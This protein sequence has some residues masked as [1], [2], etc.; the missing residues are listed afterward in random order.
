MYMLY[1]EVLILF[2]QINY[3]CSTAGLN[4]FFPLFFFVTHYQ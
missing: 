2:K 4:L 1:F 3:P